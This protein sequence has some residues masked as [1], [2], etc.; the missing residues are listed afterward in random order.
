M[1]AKL[2]GE[3][4]KYPCLVDKRFCKTDIHVEITPEGVNKYGEPYESII[5][6][7]KCNYQDTAKTVLTADKVLIQLNGIALLR[8]EIAPDL[9][10]LSGG[11]ANIYGV[12]RTIFKGT[13]ARN[14]DGTVN[15]CKLELM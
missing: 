10:T 2:G 8:G 7:T 14:P 13:K 4:M 11:K 1:P 15:Y 6:E 9:P 12:E 5:I 3:V